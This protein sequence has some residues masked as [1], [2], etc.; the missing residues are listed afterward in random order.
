MV[1]FDYE[2][3]TISHTFGYN[4]TVVFHKLQGKALNA[5]ETLLA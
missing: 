3:N 5:M 2:H 4:T 1:V